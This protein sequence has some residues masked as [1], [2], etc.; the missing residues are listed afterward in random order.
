MYYGHCSTAHASHTADDCSFFRLLFFSFCWEKK[1]KSTCKPDQSE[2][3][4]ARG[5]SCIMHHGPGHA[6][7]SSSAVACADGLRRPKIPN[8][9]PPHVPTHLRAHTA[10][11]L[12]VCSFLRDDG[13]QS[14]VPIMKGARAAPAY[15]LLLTTTTGR[16]PP[17]TT[18]AQRLMGLPL[19]RPIDSALSVYDKA[20]PSGLLV[21]SFEEARK[22][23]P[24]LALASPFEYSIFERYFTQNRLPR[25]H[26][27]CVRSGPYLTRTR[28]QSSIGIRPWETVEPP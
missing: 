9:Y 2:K 24:R 14:E 8:P 26:P 12:F 7:S 1:K 19:D 18:A 5:P 23:K 28:P 13:F 16:C 11:L 17:T 25:G 15:R 6:S 20:K 10:A 3:S 21:C 4:N 22:N 27:P